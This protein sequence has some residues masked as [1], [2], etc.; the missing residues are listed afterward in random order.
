MPLPFV[1]SFSLGC[2]AM[3]INFYSLLNLLEGIMEGG[4]G[5]VT[6]FTMLLMGKFVIL[7][8]AVY[9][10]SKLVKLDLMAFGI[11]FFI[12]AISATYAT[13]GMQKQEPTDIK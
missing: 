10:L 9:A 8:A 7:A 6:A 3:M 5:K 4:T 13:S 11:G 1:G 12:V 2:I